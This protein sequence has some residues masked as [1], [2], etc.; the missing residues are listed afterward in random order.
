MGCCQS[1]DG[2]APFEAVIAEN[3]GKIKES[4]TRETDVPM[5]YRS[6]ELESIGNEGIIT[7]KTERIFKRKR[8]GTPLDIQ[9]LAMDLPDNSSEISIES[10][11]NEDV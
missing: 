11:K 9:V 5:N 4:G 2:E 3:E 8:Q 7:E 6:K 1:Y 10:W